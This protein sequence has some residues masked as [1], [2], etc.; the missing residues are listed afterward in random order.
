MKQ[1]WC[2]EN[3]MQLLRL[4]LEEL[5]LALKFLDSPEECP[6]EELWELTEL[7]WISLEI[8]AS[9]LKDQQSSHP[10]Q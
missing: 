6:P 9:R 7:E 10:V 8:L 2:E 3:K 1:T 4:S 5:E